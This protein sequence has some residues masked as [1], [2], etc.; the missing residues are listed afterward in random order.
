MRAC[1]GVGVVM[2]N[3]ELS[4]FENELDVLLDKMV[5]DSF[6]VLHRIDA[7]IFEPVGAMQLKNPTHELK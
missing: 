4:A 5:G 3:E 7:H 2:N 6:K 1:R